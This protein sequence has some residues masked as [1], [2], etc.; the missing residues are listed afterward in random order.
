MLVD[1]RLEEQLSKVEGEI[2]VCVQVL[3]Q[4][5]ARRTRMEALGMD[6]KYEAKYEALR[7]R[8]VVL[9]EKA[10]ELRRSLQKE[11]TYFES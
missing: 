5:W 7:A 2:A 1:A 6:G 8:L 11:V 4:T 3:K 9:Q 10:V